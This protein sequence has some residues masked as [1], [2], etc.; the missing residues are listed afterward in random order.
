MNETDKKELDEALDRISEVKSVIENLAETY[1]CKVA[2]LSE[3]QESE[4][5]QIDEEA[6]ELERLVELLGTAIA[7][8]ESLIA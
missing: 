5:G 2:D 7:I 3:A 4:C 8:G 1:L 6:N